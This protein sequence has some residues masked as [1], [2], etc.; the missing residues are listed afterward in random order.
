MSPP[1]RIF[2]L[3]AGAVA[4]RGQTVADSI[5]TLE[6][7]TVSAQHR[8][9][10]VTAVPISLTAWSGDFL[11]THGVARYEDL[12]PLVPG[13]FI[14]VQSPNHPSIN[15]RGINTDVNDPRAAMRVSLFQDGIPISRATGSVVE[16][17]DLERI[18]VLKGPQS[19][20]FGRSAEAG[21][22]ALIFRHPTPARES[23]LTLGAGDYGLR[24]AAGFYNT[25]LGSDRLLGRLAFTAVHRDGTVANLADGSTL[26]GRSTVA[27]RPSLR[28]LSADDRT[29]TDL[30]INWQRDTPPGAAM[31]STV[32]PPAQ[33]DTDPYTAAEL[34]RGAA[35]G[36][37]R[38]VWGAT[39]KLAHELAPAWQLHATTGW[40]AFESNEESDG[41][42]S[43]LFLLESSDR[44]S[45]REFN[46][47]VRVNFDAG[48]RF[49]AFGGVSY[50]RERADQ[51][52]GLHTDER[53]AWPFL[54]GSFRAGLIANGVPAT[55][56]NLAVPVLNPLVAQPRLPAGFAAFASVPSLA[57]LAPL[58]NAPLK[59]EHSDSRLQDAAL[60]AFDV[61]LDGSWRVT[62]QLELTAGARLSFEDQA[63]GYRVDPSPV[64]S[65]IGFIFGASPNFA[66]AP[67]AGR[68]TDADR[69]TGWAGRLIA[70]YTFTPDLDAYASLSRGRRPEVLVITSQDRY[71]VSEE[72]IVNAEV[73]LKGRAL[74][75][76][77][78]YAAALFEY[79]YRHFHTLVQDP[80]NATRYIAVDAGRATGRG[81]EF[82]LQGLLNSA[83][84]VFATYGCTDATF[85]ATGEDGQ[86]QRYAGSSPRLTA[87]H[88]AS[89][90]ATLAREVADCGRLEFTP[91][92][93][94]RSG[95]YFDDDNTRLGGTLHQGGFARVN[96]RLA[97]RSPRRLWEARVSADNL[98]AKKFLIEAGNIGTDF[99]L[100]TVV[101]G[102]PRLVGLEVTRRF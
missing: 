11:E 89:L 37:D 43:R 72:S 87:R 71:R 47:E 5:V 99:G 69:A 39:L 25:P 32:I 77:L 101:R 91:V 74:Q 63:T 42:G 79:H 14:S 75:H 2:L 59:P 60:D 85:D 28:W 97:W 57:R 17:F 38:T 94:Y 76:R 10:A 16:L 3:L 81:G 70:R 67:T 61:F 93:Q 80:A 22:M 36:V 7:L 98:F 84:Q 27:V 49:S 48:G 26:N 15:L 21:A 95:H 24:K 33:G 19:T 96:L 12:A 13:L 40:R 102:E 55:L 45:G 100:P 65:T 50:A 54:S 82:S 66:V 34:N 64:P 73:G 90:G 4:L 6:P 62:D 35:L 86:P 53:Q 23:A 51:R 44:S 31:K 58:A 30:I 8:D 52:I 83:V 29:T 9:Q 20:L 1:W 68:L 88:T 78:I 18:E 56:A 46:Q 41:D 92:W